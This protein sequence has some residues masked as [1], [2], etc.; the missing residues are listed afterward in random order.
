MKNTML[1]TREKHRSDFILGTQGYFHQQHGKFANME[2]HFQ[3]VQ[4]N[5]WS[6]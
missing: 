6:S 4:D 2:G 1:S 3:R 5:Y